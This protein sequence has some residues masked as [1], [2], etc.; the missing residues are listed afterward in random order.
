MNQVPDLL[1]CRTGSIPMIFWQ[2]SNY[3]KAQYTFRNI[4]QDRIEEASPAAAFVCIIKYTAEELP[5]KTMD[6]EEAQMNIYIACRDL[7]GN[8]DTDPEIIESFRLRSLQS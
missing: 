4:F 1:Q 7:P 2:L 6:A 8:S 3:Q 5:Q